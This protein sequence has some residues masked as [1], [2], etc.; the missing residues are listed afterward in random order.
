MAAYI[1]HTQTRSQ[2]TG[3][4]YQVDD[5]VSGTTGLPLELFVFQTGSQAF[6]HVATVKDLTDYPPNRPDAV[7]SN[8]GFYRQSRVTQVFDSVIVAENF[9]ETTTA[10]LITLAKQYNLVV[11]KFIGVT[12]DQQLP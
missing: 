2:P 7:V 5:V 11:N 6:D 4:T 10:R 8:L 3:E 12:A 9:A 1:T